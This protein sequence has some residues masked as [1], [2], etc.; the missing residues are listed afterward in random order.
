MYMTILYYLDSSVKDHLLAGVD[1]KSNTPLHLAAQVGLGGDLTKWFID[2]YR[3]KGD[4][5][6]AKNDIGRTAFHVAAIYD[7]QVFL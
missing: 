3:G 5:L 1:F 7:N 2:L 6:K 4:K